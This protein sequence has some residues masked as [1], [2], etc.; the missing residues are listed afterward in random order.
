MDFT[1]YKFGPGQSFGE[2]KIAEFLGRGGMGAVYSAV[3]KNS[4]RKVAI[5]LI[6]NKEFGITQKRFLREAEITANLNHPNIVRIYTAGAQSGVFYLVMEYIN[7]TTLDKYLN[8]H[9]MSVHQKARLLYP[10]AKALAYAHDQNVVHRD[11]KPNN[12]MIDGNGTPKLMDF[13]LAK[14]V[15]SDRFAL[16]QSGEFS[17]TPHYMAP[18]VLLGKPKEVDFRVDI[19]AFGAIMYEVMAGQMMVGGKKS[20]EVF[21][22]IRYTKPVML[23]KRNNKVPEQLNDIWMMC[24][25]E[26]KLRYESTH[27]LV[28][29]LENFLNPQKK[30]FRRPRFHFRPVHGIILACILLISVVFFLRE[31]VTT[32]DYEPDKGI[33][34]IRA[35]NSIKQRNFSD[36]IYDLHILR[37][38]DEKNATALLM[39]AYVLSGKYSLAKQLFEKHYKLQDEIPHNVLLHV[40]I[41][42]SKVAQIQDKKYYTMS[43]KILQKILR[44][45]DVDAKILY[46]AHFYKGV[47]LF[48]ERNYSLA[49]SHFRKVKIVLINDNQMLNKL[50]FY[51]GVCY[52]ETDQPHKAISFLERAQ[53]QS[54]NSHEILFFLGQAYLKQNLPSRAKKAFEKCLRVD[55]KNSAYRTFYA[56]SLLRQGKNV[57]CQHILQDVFVNEEQ[58]NFTVFNGL[59]ELGLFEPILQQNN[60]VLLRNECTKKILPKLPN[61]FI[62]NLVAIRDKYLFSFQERKHLKTKSQVDLKPILQSLRENKNTSLQLRIREHL[63]SLR[64]QSNITKDLKNFAQKSFSDIRSI[65]YEVV[66]Q[67][68]HTKG[69][70]YV[71]DHYYYL[72]QFFIDSSALRGF[73]DAI[74]Y[75]EVYKIL[76]SHPNI[77]YKYL[78][79]K[80]LIKSYKIELLDEVSLRSNTLESSIIATCVLRQAGFPIFF[81]DDDNRYKVLETNLPAQQQKFLIYLVCHSIYYR[82]HFINKMRIEL[83]KKTVAFLEKMLQNKDER[84]QLCAAGTLISSLNNT[85]ED[86]PA[87]LSTYAQKRCQQ[88]VL[89][90]L[91]NTSTNMRHYAYMYLW[92]SMSQNNLEAQN[93]YL[94]HYKKGLRDKDTSI[95]LVNLFFSDSFRHHVNFPSLRPILRRLIFKERKTKLMFK[96]THVWAQTSPGQ[97]D[98]RSLLSN[99]LLSYNEKTFIYTMLFIHFVSQMNQGMTKKRLQ[100]AIDVIELI[101]SHTPQDPDEYFRGQIYFHLSLFGQP[102]LSDIYKEK[103]DLVKTI[104][105]THLHLP[106]V[107]ESV[108]R[109][110]MKIHLPTRYEKIKCLKE[111]AKSSHPQLRK[112]SYISLTALTKKYKDLENMVKEAKESNDEARKEGT[113]IGL[114][115]RLMYYEV[116]SEQEYSRYIALNE[117][118][119]AKYDLY[120]EKLTSMA[121]RLKPLQKKWLQILTWAIDLHPEAKYLYEK[122]L[123]LGEKPTQKTLWL[124]RKA[125]KKN[126]YPLYR[127][128]LAKSLWKKH[129]TEQKKQIEKQLNFIKNVN[130]VELLRQIVDLYEK[131]GMYDQSRLL[132][133]KLFLTQPFSALYA[134]KMS[135]LYETTSKKRREQ[136][137]TH[138]N[139][140]K[141]IKKK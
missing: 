25:T 45:Q 122:A 111:F 87:R 123:L 22:N 129:G 10:I 133:Y 1:L 96:A 19:Y 43:D 36:A 134:N 27:L 18:E 82:A 125:I 130:R 14:N 107:Q 109:F 103:S 13:G 33:L 31:D 37:K 119:E 114:Y 17:G 120:I 70:E 8:K 126:D 30:T 136:F 61:L 9:R 86:T 15:A 84:I 69:E 55:P 89:R 28:N 44:L 47:L 3:H 11:L 16:T 71:E 34:L 112:A 59:C 24:V 32:M 128:Q 68:K 76:I 132:Y 51:L 93:F 35:K 124:L 39:E 137:E 40:A 38:H 63:L 41:L 115:N 62:E 6:F 98:M 21:Q 117:P 60:L 79:A 77:F 135:T 101:S 138:E 48:E 92:H 80:Y 75:D 78:A 7:G 42:Y 100:L 99:E 58:P 74:N 113:A 53:K 66:T 141:R 88:I 83:G 72:A 73:H 97:Q 56:R 20:E 57:K 116:M 26:K 127:L 23:N 46:K 94:D 139:L 81:T 54:V 50:F 49:L 118:I 140:C 52:L 102:N 90:N 95:I 108:M 91:N 12:I 29:D 110:L 65:I 4:G 106:V 67:I 64:Y 85:L 121:Y 5:K 131:L 2:Y 105:L 104:I